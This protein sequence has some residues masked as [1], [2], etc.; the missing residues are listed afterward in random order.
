M[1]E[2]LNSDKEHKQVFLA[3]GQF[4][5]LL[6]LL[7]IVEL[8]IRELYAKMQLAMNSFDFSLEPGLGKLAT[9]GIL[10]GDAVILGLNDRM[11][12]KY[13]IGRRYNLA[14]T[15]VYYY[16]RSRLDMHVP[17]DD[18][19]GLFQDW[20]AQAILAR[21]G[22]FM[23]CHNALTNLASALVGK[24]RCQQAAQEMSENLMP[25]FLL[26]PAGVTAVQLA[27]ERGWK[28]FTPT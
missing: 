13:S 9:L 22:S 5:S 10:I 4:R 3:V 17:P 15:N 2:C 19:N 11:W 1:M 12:Q 26:V 24:A 18:P 21:G 20:S 7:H 28:L 16:A 6:G 8:D 25:G 14:K 27:Q 23:V